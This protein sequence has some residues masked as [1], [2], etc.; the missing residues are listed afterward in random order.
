M[1]AENIILFVSDGDLAEIVR[2]R[3]I[4]ADPS[5]VLEAQ[6]DDFFIALAP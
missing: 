2:L 5:V 6:M 1:I 4:D 3:S